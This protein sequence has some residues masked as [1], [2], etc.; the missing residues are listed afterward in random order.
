MSAPPAGTSK[1]AKTA[2]LAPEKVPE[3]AAA[4]VVAPVPACV[5]S[6]EVELKPVVE[7]PVAETVPVEVKAPEPEEV[8]EVE[9]AEVEKEPTEE[10]V[11]V[12]G[13]VAEE[14]PAVEA[15]AVESPAVVPEIVP[16][17]APEPI[18]PEA[19]A[20]VEVRSVCRISS[21][22]WVSPI[23]Q[24]LRQLLALEILSDQSPRS[25][26]DGWPCLES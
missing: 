2:A 12:Q 26:W 20:D 5:E 10:V 3:V 16:E 13:P 9:E 15:P 24:I 19:Q 22:I 4:P 7:E 1:K 6:P 11:E 25:F 14:A 18:V 8:V 21:R 23:N 17:P